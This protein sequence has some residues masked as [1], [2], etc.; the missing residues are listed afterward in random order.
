MQRE[1]RLLA[2][3]SLIHGSCTTAWELEAELGSGFQD[4]FTCLLIAA[5]L[6]IARKRSQPR[7]SLDDEYIMKCGIYTQWNFIQPRE[8]RALENILSEV[9]QA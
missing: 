5:L 1:V 2:L 4:A 8:W 3:P 7:C 9:T 6:T